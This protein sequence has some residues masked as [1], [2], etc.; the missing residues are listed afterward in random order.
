MVD[1]ILQKVDR[2]TMA[3]SLE[4]REPLLDHH[5][6]EWAAQLPSSF[7]LN[8]GVSKC[9]LRDITHKYIPYE[10]MHR[11]KMG[12]NIPYAD[13]FKTDLKQELIFTLSDN[14]IGTN[15]LLNGA[16]VKTMLDKF[17]KNE[18]VDFQRIWQ[19]YNFQLWMMKWMG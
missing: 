15:G 6:I 2:A 14:K 7:K 12:F 18:K 17:F 3:V 5:I 19:V 11:P 8:N 9:I 16:Q 13:W 10:I 4:G 1:D